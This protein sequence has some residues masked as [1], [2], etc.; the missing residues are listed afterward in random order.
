MS[1]RSFVHGDSEPNCLYTECDCIRFAPAPIEC[2][3]GSEVARVPTESTGGPGLD[4]CFVDSSYSV[5][6]CEKVG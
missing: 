4:R 3:T 5:L 6:G 1:I 2:M